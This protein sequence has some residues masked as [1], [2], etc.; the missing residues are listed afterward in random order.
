M[1]S[2]DLERVNQTLS[3][4]RD[5]YSMEKRY[6]RK[7]GVP[8]WVNLTVALVRNESGQPH[9][10]VSVVQDISDAKARREIL[11]QHKFRLASAVDVADLGF[12]EVADG[13][14]IVLRGQPAQALTG[15]PGGLDQGNLALQFWRSIFIRRTALAS[16]M[17]TA[18]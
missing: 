11:L 4:E 9:W 17:S 18:S 14:R 3:G 12:Y 16:W 15:V 13:E 10:F 5:T 2:P 8:V 6:I 7:D 1:T